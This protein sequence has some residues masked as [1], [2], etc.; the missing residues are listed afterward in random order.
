MDKLIRRCATAFL[1]MLAL[2]APSAGRA[3]DPPYDVNVILS[4]SGSA[5][6]LAASEQ[7]SMQIAETVINRQGGIKGR[8]VRFVFYDDQSSPQV[9]VQ[10]IN[11]IM[12]QSP[13]PPVVL[14]SSLIAECN[15]MLP[16]VEA[17][18]G[19]V[20]YC[21]SPSFAPPPGSYG[22]SGTV[23]TRDLQKALLTYFRLK[24][25]TRL[26]LITSTDSTGQDAEQGV[27]AAAKLPENKELELV[28]QA[29]FT[30]TDV[31]VTAQIEHIRAVKPQ[32]II[33]WSTGTPIATVL[34]GVKQVGIDEIPFATTNG[35]QIFA[36]MAQYQAFLPKSFYIPSG[37][38]PELPAGVAVDPR[39][40][41]AHK[42]F[43]DGF[44]AAGARPDGASS[45]PWD[46]TMIVVEA[47]RTLGTNAT[48][49]QLR[50][51]IAHVKDYAGILGLYDFAKS[52][53]RGLDF[54]NAVV[55]LWNGDKKSFDM[56]SQPGGAPLGR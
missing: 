17:A 46:L 49:Q 40:A 36:Q 48:A 30:P 2:A 1:A 25:L 14:G 29:H 18:Q 12:G 15:A 50:D 34:R 47:L 8:P 13:K 31:S 54:S 51:H 35:N 53:Q 6:F 42:D 56:V 37:A 11:Q 23:G 43:F 3:A 32:A 7:Q 45:L 52:P 44:A 28:E 16:I 4:L 9:T 10:L 19:P 55:T 5:A 38:W 41:K 33:G 26:A 27:V 21:I 39:V 20:V 22:F 24:G